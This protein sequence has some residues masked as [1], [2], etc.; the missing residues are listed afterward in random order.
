MRN[1]DSQGLEFLQRGVGCEDVKEADHL[2]ESG[3]G[4][5][6]EGVMFLHAFLESKEYKQRYTAHSLHSDQ[7]NSGLF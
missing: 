4:S 1:S 5:R 3:E 7:T 6:G 2:G